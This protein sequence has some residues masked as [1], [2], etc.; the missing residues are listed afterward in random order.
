MFFPPPL[1]ESDVCDIS[2]ICHQV[3]MS[4]SYVTNAITASFMLPRSSEHRSFNF[5]TQSHQKIAFCTISLCFDG[6]ISTRIK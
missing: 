6:A 4:D 3:L 5:L 2:L 1:R